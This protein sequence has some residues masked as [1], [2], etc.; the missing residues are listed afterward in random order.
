MNL[1]QTII[2]QVTKSAEMLAG[3]S[4]SYSRAGQ[5]VVLHDVLLGK[6][7]EQ[8]DTEDP[9]SPRIEYSDRDFFIRSASLVLGGVKIEPKS[10]DQICILDRD[11][12]DAGKIFEVLPLNGRPFAMADPFVVRYRVFTRQTT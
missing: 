8:A 4:A 1:L 7:T 11:H 3:V 12:P 9:S 6:D 2:S 10:R 5:T